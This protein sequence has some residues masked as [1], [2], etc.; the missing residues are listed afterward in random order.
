MKTKDQ[1]GNGVYLMPGWDKIVIKPKDVLVAIRGTASHVE[2][3]VLTIIVGFSKEYWCGVTFARLRDECSRQ[4]INFSVLRIIV[5][6]L[7]RDG[8]VEIT[9][10]GWWP[11]WLSPGPIYPTM[12]LINELNARAQR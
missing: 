9:R 4:G 7:I 11:K 5:D 2:E 8:R 6:M 1:L 12:K 10:R 3:K